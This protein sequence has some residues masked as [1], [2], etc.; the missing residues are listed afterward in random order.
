[1][2]GLFAASNYKNIY[3]DGIHTLTMNLTITEIWTYFTPC[4]SVSIA[5]FEHVIAGWEN[6]SEYL[7]MIGFPKLH[8]GTCQTSKKELSCEIS[9]WLK[10]VNLF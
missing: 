1:M 10:T 3:C 6:F 4:C 7:W 9:Y 2:D 5:N 8:L